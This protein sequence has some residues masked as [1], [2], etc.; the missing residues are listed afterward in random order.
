MVS[1]PALHIILHCITFEA[2]CFARL[3]VGT[4]L[5]A[6]AARERQVPVYA[7]ADT[8]KLFPGTAEALAHPGGRAGQAAH[9]EEDADEVA[10]AW[11][12]AAPG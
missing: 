7:V 1:V 4:Y 2:L 8:S 12:V 10:S 11:A 5:L 9:E 3:Q 6:L